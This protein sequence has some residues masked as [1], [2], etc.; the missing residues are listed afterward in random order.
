M[1]TI[2]TCKVFSKALGEYLRQADYYSQG[3]KV[4]G[5]CFGQLCEAVGLVEGA[6]ISDEAFERV[7]SNHH[8]ATG[9]QLT[10][11][12]A[13]ARR[14]GYDATFNAPK[15]VSIQAFIGGDDRLVAAHETAVNAALR[16]LE[17]FAAHQDGRGINKRYVTSPSIAAAVF[18][19]GESRALDPHLHSHAFVF[20]VVRGDSSS[21]LLALESSN[22]F[23]RARYL[24]E[25]YRN[26]LAR[27]VQKLGYAIER[28]EHGF[29]LAGISSNLIERFSK[30]AAERD[31]AVAVREAELG[32][33]LTRDEIAVLVRENRAK[34]QYELTPDDVRQRQ[35]AQVNA[36]ELRQLHALREKAKPV[37]TDRVVLAVA[38]ER[39]VE[40]VFE[41]KTVVP[42]HELTAEILRQSY[43]QHP[44]SAIKEA[45]VGGN[46][47]LLHADD[48]VTTRAALD[49]E[50]ALVAQLNTNA[51]TLAE[52]G[53]L[54]SDA[55]EKLSKEQR[56]AVGLILNSGD[57]AVVLR[58]RAGTG[59][60]HT[61]ASAIEGMAS[62]KREVA[63]F[64]P[65]TQ[66]VEILRRDGAEQAQAGRTAAAIAL[67]ETQTVQRLLVDPALQDSIRQKAVVIDEYGLLSLRQLKAVVDL[68]E[69][70]HARLVF[71]GDS[72][73]HKSVEAGD[74]ARI[75][76]HESRVTVAE[77][78]EVR[79]QSANPA[80]RA[81]ADALAGGKIAE[82]VAK[83]DAMGA[84]VE[85][86]NPTDRRVRMVNDWFAASQEIKTVRT[87][88]GVQ[89]RAKTALMVAPTWAEIDALNLHAR[90]K[91]RAAGK[92]AR[93]EQTIASLR[94]KDWT[95][96]QQKD[97][98]N[99]Q[100]G[101]VL[102]THKATKHFAKGDELRVVRKEK[103]RLVVARGAEESSISPR[104]SG[105]TWTVCEQRPLAVGAGDLL[106][107]RAVSY[108]ERAD[109]QK[110][111][112]ANGAT[113]HVRS[114]DASGRLVLADG[115]TL[116]TR[117][118]VHGYAMTSHAAQGL[119]V[120]HVFVA[121]AIS[122]E[123]LYVSTTRGRE[124]IRVFVPDREA[125]LDAAG[126]KSEARMSAMEFVRQHALGTDLRS[127]MAR[128]WRHL[129]HV[130]ACFLAVNP[131]QRPGE[132]AVESEKIV[133]EAVK[134]TVR[135]PRPAEEDFRP[136]R[137]AIHHHQAGSRMRMGF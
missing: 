63:C 127:V 107:V 69:K 14:A 90:E 15:S 57:R 76:E 16:E 56:A 112:L 78:H 103:H 101:D 134:P 118:V 110:Q 68:A 84:I 93:E 34:K 49:L 98:R 41:R 121:G 47:A 106:R 83:L 67:R 12:M 129:M 65:S 32:R 81:A 75:V 105:L 33:E 6:T 80:Y 72:G 115:S 119:T 128:G 60:T 52:L 9:E 29:E 86:E 17:T 96:A 99:Y 53:Y 130:R 4:E 73:Q 79:R 111:R 46:S 88:A 58:G 22:I 44:L 137:P 97:V 89:E 23:E 133:A 124:G 108:A 43:G 61:L 18:R 27:E 35:F 1:L 13:A 55:G 5:Q 30:R 48:K 59:K 100:P 104:Q 11:R 91:L 94:A 95:R 74:A 109:G 117:Q 36:E 38:V 7:A 85:I 26:A 42:V 116:H 25:V 132:A 135:G 125:F 51:G 102:V 120:D 131:Q 40:H 10:E 54:M 37:T 70:Q 3:M 31:R 136:P 2:R 39:A 92:L 8:A 122:R 113:V 114:V 50:R 28:R 19:H 77:L 87:K 123:G 62:I 82:G 64:A 24:T 126:L 66:A 21:R 71:V 20:N 45:V